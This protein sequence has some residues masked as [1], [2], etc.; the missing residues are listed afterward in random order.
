MSVLQRQ[1]AGRTIHTHVTMKDCRSAYPKTVGLHRLL[2]VPPV[3]SRCNR[4]RSAAYACLRFQIPL[5]LL[6]FF[7]VDFAVRIAFLQY[8]QWR[9]AVRIAAWRRL[10]HQPSDQCGDSQNDQP[11]EQQHEYELP[12]PVKRFFKP[13]PFWLSLESSLMLKMKFYT[14]FGFTPLQGQANGMMIHAS[15]FSPK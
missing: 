1:P 2:P 6:V 8:F 12:M 14:H 10:I 13:V 3:W 15:A 11:P 5:F 4:D 9:L 7:P